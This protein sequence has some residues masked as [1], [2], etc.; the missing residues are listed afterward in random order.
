MYVQLIRKNIIKI[1]KIL[2][3]TVRRQKLRFI[4]I[5]KDKGSFFGMLHFQLAQTRNGKKLFKEQ[6]RAPKTKKN[7]TSHK[8][9]LKEGESTNSSENKKKTIV[10]K[11][12]NTGTLTR[13]L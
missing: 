5:K 8:K 9:M 6:V 4:G 12:K 10:N 11:E 2:A 3:F 1:V 7:A 13:T